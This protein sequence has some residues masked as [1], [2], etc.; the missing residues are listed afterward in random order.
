MEHET[1][2]KIAKRNDSWGGVS[3]DEIKPFM[4]GLIKAGRGAN[5]L[6]N[7]TFTLIHTEEKNP[8]TNV[9]GEQLNMQEWRNS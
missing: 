7:Q 6:Y 1:E 3:S 9:M 4:C 5:A 2:Q 8:Q